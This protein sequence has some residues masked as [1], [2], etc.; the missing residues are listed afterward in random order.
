MVVLQACRP[1]QSHARQ[2]FRMQQIFSHGTAGS[3]IGSIV[4][5]EAGQPL[6]DMGIQVLTAQLFG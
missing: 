3:G 5:I 2:L 1:N 4:T 6:A